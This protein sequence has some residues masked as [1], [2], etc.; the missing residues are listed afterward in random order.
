MYVGFE[1]RGRVYVENYKREKLELI[2]IHFHLIALQ[3]S[4]RVCDSCYE[5]KRSDQNAFSPIIYITLEREKDR[6][7]GERKPTRR[8]KAGSSISNVIRRKKPD[9]TTYDV[10]ASME[11]R[12]GDDDEEEVGEEKDGREGGEKGVS[13]QSASV[14]S[15]AANPF[16]AELSEAIRKPR[17]IRN[18]ML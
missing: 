10:D 6:K 8:S 4:H 18:E 13:F 12:F 5:K 11:Y 2:V 17:T 7:E 15:V 14:G 3:E 16:Q 9:T 1:W